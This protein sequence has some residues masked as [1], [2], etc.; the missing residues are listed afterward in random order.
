MERKKYI[1]TVSLGKLE[2]KLISQI[3]RSCPYGWFSKW[4]NLKIRQSF[5]ETNKHTGSIV[6]IRLQLIEVKTKKRDKL[7]DEIKKM[8]EDLRKFKSQ[9]GSK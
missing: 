7:D 6:K 9:E 3:K 1:E 5:F 4:V 8:V 2:G